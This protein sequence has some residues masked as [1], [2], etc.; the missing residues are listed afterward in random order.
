MCT[1][2]LTG[3]LKA[4][5]CPL[6]EAM[7]GFEESFDETSSTTKNC[8]LVAQLKTNLG[9]CYKVSSSHL[10]CS[11]N[12]A[13]IFRASETLRRINLGKDCTNTLLS[14]RRRILHF[15]PISGTKGSDTPSISVLFHSL[16]WL[17]CSLW[18]G[19]GMFVDYLKC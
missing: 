9:F 11:V 15:M 17:F 18:Y 7:Y 19:C 4:K 2:Q 5:I 14:K 1:W 8:G 10:I 6:V 12:Q 16:A 13:Y 3:E